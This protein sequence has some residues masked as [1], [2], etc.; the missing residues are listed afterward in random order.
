MAELKVTIEKRDNGVSASCK[1]HDIST[2]EVVDILATAIHA[3]CRDMAIPIPIMVFALLVETVGEEGGI[4]E[5]HMNKM[6]E[7]F[8]MERADASLID[9]LKS[10]PM[11]TTSDSTSVN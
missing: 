4:S 7:L 6:A 3:I 11:A 10:T 8:G 1:A 2:V 5:E 9:T